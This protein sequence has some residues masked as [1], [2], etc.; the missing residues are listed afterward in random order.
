MLQWP[1]LS[2]KSQGVVVGHPQALGVEVASA[3]S[4]E[5]VAAS[6]LGCLLIS[7]A[8]KADL[9]M[10]LSMVD[11]RSMEEVKWDIDGKVVS[12]ISRAQLFDPQL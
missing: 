10:S 7:S 4:P 11:S 6:A 8:I 9:S 3:E 5:V 1:G 2:Q 12:S